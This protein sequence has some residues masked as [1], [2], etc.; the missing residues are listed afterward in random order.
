[1]QCQTLFEAQLVRTLG[2][3]D[4]AVAGTQVNSAAVLLDQG[5]PANDEIEDQRLCLGTGN[6]RGKSRNAMCRRANARDR[7]AIQDDAVQRRIET[8]LP[9]R[10]RI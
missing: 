3:A 8:D 4:G 5:L 7:H 1:M 6:G 9:E 10:L 2:V